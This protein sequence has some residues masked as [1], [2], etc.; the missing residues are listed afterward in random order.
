MTEAERRELVER[1]KQERIRQVNLTAPKSAIYGKEDMLNL[2]RHRV[3]HKCH[4]FEEC[5]LCYKCRAYDP[6]YESCRRCVLAKEGLLCD[7]SYHRTDIINR[8]IT[9]ERIDLDAKEQQR[10]V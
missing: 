8:M 5:P 7:T 9:R 10:A 4:N 2:P 1:Y 3:L 6:K